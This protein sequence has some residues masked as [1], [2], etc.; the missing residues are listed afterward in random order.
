M[1]LTADGDRWQRVHV[2]LGYTLADRTT[3]YTEAK[4]LIERAHRLKPDD[5]A[6]LDSLGWV[7]YRSGNLQ[8]AEIYLRQ[9]L[10]AFPDAEIAA[11]LGEV[12][13]MQGKHQE[14]REIWQQSL[15]RQPDSTIL[16]STMQRLTGSEAL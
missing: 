7:Y 16:R 11:H 12:L 15:Q 4:S 3:R 5:P 6:I 10:Q 1:H 2:T 8:Q 14:A 9:A 13:W